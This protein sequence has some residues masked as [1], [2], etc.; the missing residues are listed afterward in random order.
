MSTLQQMFR[1]DQVY[2]FLV[3]KVVD[4][5][6]LSHGTVLY[7]EDVSVSF[8]GFKAIDGLNFYVDSGELRCLIG[9]NGAG[10]TTTFNVI[11][12]FYAPSSGR[13]V[14]DGRD[15]SGMKTSTSPPG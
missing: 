11:S 6:D 2:D 8:D 13:V 5:L 15:I 12:G 1:R 14:Y 3:P 9:P 7:M 4:D 10:K